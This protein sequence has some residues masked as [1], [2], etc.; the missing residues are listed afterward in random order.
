MPGANASGGWCANRPLFCRFASEC[1][2]SS[3]K[4]AVAA[5]QSVSHYRR[6]LA[7]SDELLQ[8]RFAFNQM[9]RCP[10]FVAITNKRRI[11]QR[12][13]AFPALRAMTIQ[14]ALDRDIHRSAGRVDQRGMPTGRQLRTRC[15]SYPDQ[16]DWNVCCV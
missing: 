9:D 1:A 14:M 6:A 4:T 13:Q 5:A 2:S 3:D 8:F 11:T 16:R 10:A 15:T 12:F 7:H